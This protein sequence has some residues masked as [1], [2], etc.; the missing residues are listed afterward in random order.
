[1]SDVFNEIVR[2]R[3][4]GRKGALATII[5]V[6]GSIPSYECSKILVRDD[7]SIVGTVG[8]GCVEADVWSVAQDVMREEK[9]RRLHFNLN[10]N[11][12]YDTGLVCGGS[13]D[14]FVEPIMAT[15]TL[16]LFGGGHVS[17]NVSKVAGLAGFDIVVCDDR[18]AFANK[19]R[20]PSAVATHA[21][22]W[23]EIFPQISPNGLSYIVIATRG[24]KADLDCLRW[25]ASTQA[26]YVGMVGSKRKLAEFFKLL[27]ADGVS[28]DQLER[29]H[30]PVG[31]DIGALTPEE[32]AV[33]IVAEMIAVRRSVSPSAAS[34]TWKPRVH[35]TS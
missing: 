4:E 7:G 24:H 1:M 15:P 26:R 2:L 14:I 31:L 30:S 5:Q 6:Q 35:Q 34:L 18:E 10:A 9:P 8:G 25:A 11:P 16:Y 33:S 32:I 28:S 23:E 17:L 22:P 21:G 29:V 3:K 13:L 12:E 20:F 19:E 27:S